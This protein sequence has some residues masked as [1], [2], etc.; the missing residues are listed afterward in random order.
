MNATNSPDGA[1]FIRENETAGIAFIHPSVDT[2]SDLKDQITRF[3]L[4]G[5]RSLKLLTEALDFSEIDEVSFLNMLGE[6]R[7]T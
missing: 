5:P 2:D 4:I 1:D 6:Y 3:R 7:V